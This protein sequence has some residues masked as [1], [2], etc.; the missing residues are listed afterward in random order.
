MPINR[1]TYSGAFLKSVQPFAVKV[2]EGLIRDIVVA[3]NMQ[4]EECTLSRCR[5]TELLTS[6]WRSHNIYRQEGRRSKK[7]KLFEVLYDENSI[8]YHKYKV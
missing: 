5:L 6:N 4:R 7:W 1:T 2:T 3:G 8:L